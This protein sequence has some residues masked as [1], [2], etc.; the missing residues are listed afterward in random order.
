MDAYNYDV[1]RVRRCVIHYATPDGRMYPFCTYNSG[2]ILRDVIEK[3]C[4]VSSEQWS[5][6]KQGQTAALPPGEA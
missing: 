4:S 6:S 5:K 3:K 2:P 1:D